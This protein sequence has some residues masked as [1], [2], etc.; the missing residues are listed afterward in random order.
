[1]HDHHFDPYAI[2]YYPPPL[3]LMLLAMTSCAGLVC[4]L[5]AALL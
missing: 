1:M 4:A 5:A 3:W 2:E